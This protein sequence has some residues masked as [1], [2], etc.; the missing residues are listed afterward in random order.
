MDRGTLTRTVALVIALINQ[1]AV[2]IFGWE[3]LPV[4]EE[5]AGMIINLAY[6]LFTVVLTTVTAL[7][8]WFKNNYVTE[9]GKKQK[10]VIE[11]SGVK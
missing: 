9:K 8:A 3:P 2:S 1:I 6:E 4:D 10:E 7:I 5:Q 11:R